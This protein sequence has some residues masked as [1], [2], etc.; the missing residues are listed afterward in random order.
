MLKK[1]L[2]TLGLFA[3]LVSTIA[4]P[5]LAGK[6]VNVAPGGVLVDGK[7]AP[8]LALHGYDPVAYFKQNKP[9][10]G[11]ADYATIYKK[12]TYRFS[13]KENLEAFKS[14]PDKYAPAYVGFCAYGVSVNAKF[15]GDPR[16][17]TI[18]KGKLY[19][20]L[21]KK[22]SS[23][24]NKDIDGAVKKAEANWKTLKNK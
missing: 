23:A 10:Q 18:H 7:P 16:Y 2:L 4:N 14:N 15:D 13:S 12:A 20:N 24:F 3:G 8:G 22:I 17:W 21:D 1:L 19:L 11:V 6:A 9:V 5:A